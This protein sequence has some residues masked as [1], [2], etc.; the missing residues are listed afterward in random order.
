M[1]IQ[2]A[3]AKYKEYQIQMRRYFHAH[4]EL[5]GK[6][7]QTSAAIKKELDTMGIS[8]RP[9][10]LE[11]G[12]LATI[13]GSK[14]GRTIL[15]RG[16]MDALE[17]QEETGAPYASQT[18][19]VMHA[20]GHDCH[21]SMLLTAA[22]I[23]HDMKEELCGTVKLAFQPAEE[24]GLGALAMIEDGALEGVDGCFAIHVWSDIEKGRVFCNAGAA[25]ASAGKFQI[26]LK[27][28][29]GHGATPHLCVDAAVA[30][31]ATVMNLQTIVSRELSPQ[32]SACVTVGRIQ[33]GTRFNCVAENA[34]IEG[35]TRAFDR[36]VSDLFS[37]RIERI[38]KDTAKAF[39]AE[40]ALTY[41]YLT[42]PVV[43][44]PEMAELVQDASRKVVAPDAPVTIPPLSGGEDFSFFMSRVPGAIALLGVRNEA[45]DAV[46]PQHS[47]KYCVDEEM[48]LHGAMLYAQV[49][50]DFNAV[51]DEK[52][53]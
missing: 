32:D 37:E 14:P 19:G 5:S 44:H 9:C 11:T 52:N 45:C 18:E 15:I 31:S 49:A 40:A 4:P 35:T 28:M 42:D 24:V 17:V 23:L 6:E 22:H 36:K 51:K 26:D 47:N 48:L 38:A 2:E 25:M 34:C 46:W 16:D 12:I 41:E 29:G 21:I 27:G 33:S 1:T 7:F 10:G 20:C 13:T 43:N 3:A 39:R 53:L 8:W 50:M 30:A